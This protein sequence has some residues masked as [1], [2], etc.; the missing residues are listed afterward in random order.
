MDIRLTLPYC[1]QWKDTQDPF[2]QERV[3]AI[4]ALKMVLDFEDASAPSLDELIQ[5]G[6]AIDGRDPQL[7]WK[8]AALRDLAS[9]YGIELELR[10]YKHEGGEEQFLSEA[11]MLLE[12]EHPIIISI[13]LPHGG[14]HLVVL[15][16]IKVDDNGQVEG[17]HLNDPDDKN[18]FG[19]GYFMRLGEFHGRFR[20]LT[21]FCLGKP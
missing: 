18:G 14:S 9:E 5:Q 3:C 16:G 7:G 21:L 8:H 17:F 20:K 13:T 10:E 6:V 11:Q 19:E 12:N 2:W 1:S 15:T 4:A